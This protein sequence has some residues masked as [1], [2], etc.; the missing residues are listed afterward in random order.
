[1][2]DEQS[3]DWWVSATRHQKITNGGVFVKNTISD[4]SRQFARDMIGR[5]SPQMNKEVSLNQL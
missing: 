3:L 5:G 2:T 1:M 4:W